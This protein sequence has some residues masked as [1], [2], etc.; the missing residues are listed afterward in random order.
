MLIVK[1]FNSLRKAEH[2]AM[3]GLTLTVCG[4]ALMMM[5]GDALADTNNQT[6]STVTADANTNQTAVN[7]D[8]TNQSS[9]A[10]AQQSYQNVGV[11]AQ[12]YD[13]QT[14]AANVNQTV[15][16][17]T[18]NKQ[19]GW[20]D[21]TTY[22]SENLHVQGWHAAD[23]S[24]NQ[25]N[26]FLIIYDQTAH[27]QLAVK[28][29]TNDEVS[30]PDVQGVH[31]DIANAAKSGFSADF[32]IDS[33]AYLDH[34]LALVSRYSELATGNGDNGHSR[35]TDRWFT[36]PLANQDNKASL[37]QATI[38]NGQLHVAGWHA[39]KNSLSQTHHY[40]IIVNGQG[41]ELTRRE[42]KNVSRPDVAKVYP[43]L[44]NADLSGFSEDFQLQANF[45]NQPLRIIS[46]YSADPA[47]NHKY[48][49]VWFNPVEFV[50]NHAN[51]G[52]LD[53]VNISNGQNVTVTGWHAADDSIYEPYHFLILYDQTGHRQVASAAV[54]TIASDDVH[55]VNPGILQSGHSR[56]NY[57]FK[58][59]NLQAGHTYQLVSRYSAINTGNG[60]NGRAAYTDYWYNAFSLDNKMNSYVDSWSNDG[61]TLSVSGWMANSDSVNK[62][63]AFAILLNNNNKEV[64]RV[65]LNLVDRDDVARQLP[66][67]WNSLH[68]GFTAKFDPSKIEK[69][70]FQLVLRFSNQLDGEGQYD[71]VYTAKYNTDDGYFDK[72]DFNNHTNV[73]TVQGWHAALDTQQRP[74]EFI[75]AVAYINGEQHEMYRWQLTG[76]QK[77]LQR[78]DIKQKYGY[79]SNAATSG[80]AATFDAAKLHNHPFSLVHRFSDKSDGEGNNIDLWIND[81]GLYNGLTYNVT[82]NTVNRFILNNRIGHAT[83]EYHYVIPERTGSSKGYAYNNGKPD[84]VV[85]HETANPN[86]SIEG[87]INYE[88]THFES[89]FVH[90]FVDGNRIIEISPTDRP[91]WGAG[92]AANHRAVQF[93]QVEVYGRDNFARE[94]ANA[95]YYAAYNIV[96]YKIH[97]IFN[98]G[99]G[100]NLYS[101]HMV[102]QF[103]G[104]T[105]HTDPDAYWANRAGRY[106]G[107]GYNMNDFD[108]LVKYAIVNWVL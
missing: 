80:F 108:E 56:F 24:V 9:T 55:R 95:A 88:R 99:S 34:Q 6:V 2:A 30:R 22:S 60:D 103:M 84:M 26:H 57:S 31:P 1:H 28:N 45:L 64:D 12:V 44:Y 5:H 94:L 42:I 23:Q 92:P 61:K 78:P 73:L 3:A 29:I 90:A 68:S 27:Q 11:K 32:N 69:G 83:I 15:N 81:L 107:S 70:T 19:A 72:A 93:E 101:H 53:N 63:Y 41:R 71:D 20:L 37:D 65:R 4:T 40:I 51:E 96:K 106:F 16:N 52:Y 67:V 50:D 82:A 58:D 46:R 49:D 21:K 77:N 38:S 10:P 79:D 98:M 18:G 102:S 100:S 66:Q 75:I 86:D 74:Y 59:V 35:Y 97:P 89:A 13:N 14:A 33:T 7:Q 17:E 8:S 85:V 48:T 91:C 87:E 54:E 43:D 36:L 39:T 104:G 76:S 47:G 62:P 105:D 25:P